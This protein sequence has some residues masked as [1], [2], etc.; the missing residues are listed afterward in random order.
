MG[1]FSK[2]FGKK[3]Q[4]EQKPDKM[5][6]DFTELI[7]CD[8]QQL[9]DSLT[10]EEITEL[11]LSEYAL[12]AQ[13]GYYPILVSLSDTL[14]EDIWSVYEDEGDHEEYRNRLMSSDLS[15]GGEFLSKRFK[16]YVDMIKEEEDE[17]Y[18]VEE[19]YGEYSDNIKPLSFFLN[20]DK[21]SRSDNEKLL[22]L[23]VP[24]DEP[25]KVFAWLPIGGWNECPETEDVMAVCKYWYEKYKAVP[26]FISKDELQMYVATPINHGD[27][28]VKLAEEQYGFCNDTV[29]QGVGS[30][31]S[32]AGSLIGSNIWYFWWD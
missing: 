5:V 32:L 23:R 10:K 11:Y 3:E 15:H 8:W 12:G 2:L 26:A 9:S 27:D 19:L 6:T 30:I 28:A 16:E 13:N 4:S 22:L 25:W 7:G 21:K 18:S 24:A 29:D 14:L 1:I 31:M 17:N 20:V